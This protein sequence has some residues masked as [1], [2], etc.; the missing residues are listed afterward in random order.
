MITGV[1]L[2]RMELIRSEPIPGTRKICS[3]TMAPPK[4]AG[5]WRATRVTTGMRALRTTCFTMVIRSARPLARAVV[6]K[7]S[8]ITSRTADRT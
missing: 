5:I 7:S 1:S 3:V 4:M 6:T 8:R 2:A